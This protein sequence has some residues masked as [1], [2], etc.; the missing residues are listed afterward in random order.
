MTGQ[1]RR[2]GGMT[3]KGRDGRKG[4]GREPAE[5]GALLGS[6]TVLL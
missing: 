1:G 2:E 3:G 4:A 5:L 6:L